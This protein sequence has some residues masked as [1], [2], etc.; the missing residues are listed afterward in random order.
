MKVKQQTLH[1]LCPHLKEKLVLEALN[2]HLH[3]HLA[4]NQLIED[5]LKIYELL[6]R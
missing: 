1:V 2:N 4:R 6:L 5:N 3:R